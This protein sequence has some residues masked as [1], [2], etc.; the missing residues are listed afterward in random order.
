[1]ILEN[2][3]AVSDNGFKNYFKGLASLQGHQYVPFAGSIVDM[4]DSYQMMTIANKE[5]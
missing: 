5:N 3:E 1:M 4:A 2:P